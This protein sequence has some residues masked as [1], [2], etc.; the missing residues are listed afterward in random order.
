M[1]KLN[2][3]EIKPGMVLGADVTDRNGRVLLKNGLEISDRHL[4]ILKQWGITD[5]DIKGASR[6][7]ITAQAVGQLDQHALEKAEQ[8]HNELFRYTDRQNPFV[9]E[10]YRLCVLRSVHQLEGGL[11]DNKSK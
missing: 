10:I 4:K 9:N 11:D 6:E 8:V 5:A 3:D 2:L 7:E 1:G